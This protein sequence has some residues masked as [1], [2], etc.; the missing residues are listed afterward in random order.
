MSQTEIQ[1][2]IGTL[3]KAISSGTITGDNLVM[4]Q[5][6]LAELKTKLTGAADKTTD[7]P[8]T[9]GK[10]K[11]NPNILFGSPKHTIPEKTEQLPK[12]DKLRPIIKFED[13][14][15]GIFVI[16]LTSE[17]THIISTFTEN[18][19]TLAQRSKN[20]DYEGITM[21]DIIDGIEEQKNIIIKNKDGAQFHIF[22]GGIV[23][24][25]N[26]E[27]NDKVTVNQPSDV[28]KIVKPIA[29]API[30]DQKNARKLMQLVEVHDTAASINLGIDT[31]MGR[32]YV[33][34]WATF[35]IVQIAAQ[36]DNKYALLV[37][38]LKL[39]K[40]SS[41]QNKTS[42]PEKTKQDDPKTVKLTYTEKHIPFSGEMHPI[43]FKDSFQCY[44]VKAGEQYEVTTPKIAKEGDV[45][46][47]TSTG[48]PFT[49]L[50]SAA[51]QHRAIIVD[52]PL[53]AAKAA[54]AAQKTAAKT[55]DLAIQEVQDQDV[56]DALRIAKKSN[57]EA[58]KAIKNTNLTNLEQTHG[59]TIPAAEDTAN[60]MRLVGWFVEHADKFNDSESNTEITGI[61]L[62]EKEQSIILEMADY[63]GLVGGIAAHLGERNYYTLCVK[64]FDLKK[65]KAKPND[66]KPIVSKAQLR[67]VYDLQEAKKFVSVYKLWI[68]YYTTMLSCKFGQCSTAEKQSYK[69]LLENA[70]EGLASL[71]NDD[72]QAY[73]LKKLVKKYKGSKETYREAYARVVDAIKNNTSPK[74]ATPN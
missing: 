32:E 57:T 48:F 50:H 55:I 35:D 73:N 14:D 30:Q 29:P 33:P 61:Y 60:V 43:Q 1:T 16:K 63:T 65:I 2:K 45:I 40:A 18:D 36:D 9:K 6:K 67:K 41:Q 38:V 69:Q 10:G 54:E 46:I 52:N 23:Y 49:V 37:S 20:K 26:W 4:M 44:R 56:E 21:L 42:E 51:L 47:L 74:L 24:A 68:V 5:T 71:D 58:Q 64:Q 62:S 15:T 31:I 7:K 34:N 12:M 28:I 11:A 3:E 66:L 17:N 53:S 70:K 25:D 22:K 59:C 72:M 39:R 19:L 27:T 8:T 13:V